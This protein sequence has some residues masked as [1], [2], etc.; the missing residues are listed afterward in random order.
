MALTDKLS[1]IGNA[2]RA[3][4]GKTE[5][6]TLDQMPEEIASIVTGGGNGGDYDIVVTDNADGTQ[7]WAITDASGGTVVEP[8]LITKNVTSN[9]TYNA[10]ADGAD[11]YSSVVINVETEPVLESISITANGTYTPPEGT[12]GYNSGVV[13]GRTGGGGGGE[14]LAACIDRR[15]TSIVVPS[16]VTKIGNYAFAN[17]K[18]LV[19]V[20]LHNGITEIGNYAFY[21]DTE[22]VSCPLPETLGKI[23]SYAFQSCGKLNLSVLPESLTTLGEYCFNA[24]VSITISSVPHGVTSIPRECFSACNS[25]TNFTIHNAVQ[26]IDSGAFRLCKNLATVTFKGTPTGIINPGA[27]TNCTNLTDIYVPWSEGAVAHAPWGA[28]NATIHYDS[29]T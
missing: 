7:S 26:T 22:L 9:G 1:A 17:C 20:S 8:V 4:T 15:I 27:F 3:K 18:Q 5:M 2:I 16:I 12:D 13:N 6:L 11:G 10:V 21:F 25:I 14:D 28:T 24:C 29:I 23:G 19:N